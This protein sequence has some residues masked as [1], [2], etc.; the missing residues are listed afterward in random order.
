MARA[1]AMS[2][3]DLQLKQLRQ[4]VKVAEKG[5]IRQAAEALSITQ[6]ALSRNIRAIEDNLQVKLM[7]RGP[8]G[9]ALTSFGDALVAYAKI[10][11]ANLRFA[12]DEIDDL[13]GIKGGSV[14]IGIGPFEGFMVMHIAI[15]RFLR[16]RENSEVSLIE[17]DFDDLSL[18][19][20]SG[21]IDFMFGPTHFGD[22]TPGLNSEVLAEFHPILAV[23]AEHPLL[24][25]NRVT[26]H[27]LSEADW[28][29][30]PKE[31]RARAR[32]NNIFLSRG[33]V[34]PKGPIEMTPGQATIALLRRHDLVTFLSR[35]Q[36]ARELA[37]GAIRALPVDEPEFALPM[38]L[39]V[40]E[41]GELSPA[42]KDMIVE[43]KNACR[44]VGAT[45]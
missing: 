35:Q 24:R 26:F 34:P 3:S 41:F 37:E 13:K 15:D 27:E 20:L 42:C 28:I 10:I 9:V 33:L 29:L 21:E 19:V 18:K 12:A 7:E 2:I 45:L 14:K 40:R 6:P 44:E 17:G 32:L 4:L 31:V 30:P 22:P 8:R 39:T 36:V 25:R 43:I 38:Q 16:Q 5:S 1:V 23:R 11:E